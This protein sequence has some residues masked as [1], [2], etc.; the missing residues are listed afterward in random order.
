MKKKALYFITMLAGLLFI[1]CGQGP[2]LQQYFV[3]KMDDSA[4]LI[5]NIPLNL[6]SLFLKKDISEEDRRVIL[7][8]GKLNLLFYRMKKD[9]LEQYKEEVGKLK[10]ILAE[11]RY[12]HLMDFKAFDRAQGNLLFEGTESNI[13]EGIVFVESENFGFGVLRILGDD[14]NPAALMRL[15]KKVDP[16]QLE[17]Q[18]KNSIGSMGAIFEDT[19][20]VE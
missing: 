15:G 6:D 17:K 11:N 8:V 12:Q 19:D 10:K 5:V 2:S 18:V 16:N 7:S 1:S 3:E 14:I 4:F 20:T 9:Q 13:D